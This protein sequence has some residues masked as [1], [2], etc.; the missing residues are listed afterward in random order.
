MMRPQRVR[1]IGSVSGWVTL[2]KPFS[3]TSIT[4]CHCASCMPGNTASSWMPALL[5][6]TWIGPSAS[7][8]SS[9][10]GRRGRIRDVEGD[11]LGLAA[12][13][14]IASTTA[15]AVARPR[16]AWTMTCKPSWASRRQMAAPMP[17]LPPVTSARLRGVVKGMLLNRSSSRR[18]PQQGRVQ[19]HGRAALEQQLRAGF[20]P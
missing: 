7:S 11:G 18:L 14:R 8:A 5:T 9:A 1:I 3:D 2:K 4:R 15:W 20:E 12:L 17:P 16:L 19:H 6:T 10:A 13:R